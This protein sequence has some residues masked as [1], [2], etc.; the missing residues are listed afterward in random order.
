MASSSNSSAALA[1]PS[2]SRSS[3]NPGSGVNNNSTGNQSVP[4]Y[5]DPTETPKSNDQF[6]ENQDPF[7]STPQNSFENN[8]N[9][10][11]E[12]NQTPQPLGG[13]STEMNDQFNPNNNSSPTNNSSTNNSS[14]DQFESHFLRILNNF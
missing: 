1:L 4:S 13:N 11:F 3:A 10:Q 9:D 6:L 8:S 14:N 12:S 7:P 2:N 5:N